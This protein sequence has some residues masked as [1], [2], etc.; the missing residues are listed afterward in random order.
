MKR[1]K[2]L[3]RPRNPV[4]RS[5][6]LAKGGEHEAKGKHAKRARQKARLRRQLAE[7]L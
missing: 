6:L 7:E 4:A 5:P 3:A 1:A 2:R